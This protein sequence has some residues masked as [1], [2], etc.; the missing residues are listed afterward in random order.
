MWKLIHT[1]WNAKKNECVYRT[2]RP[3]HIFAMLLIETCN[4]GNINTSNNGAQT[5][6]VLFFVTQKGVNSVNCTWTNLII[7]HMTLWS[8]KTHWGGSKKKYK[9]ISLPRLVWRG[10]QDHITPKVCL[11]RNYKAESL[12]RLEFTKPNRFRS[13][14][15]KRN[16]FGFIEWRCI[17]SLHNKTRY[18]SL[19]QCLRRNMHHAI[20]TLHVYGLHVGGRWLELR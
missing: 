15:E 14:S 19:S 6:H 18:F 11:K 13:L 16:V 17:L 5:K 12:S 20:S 10:I 7:L 3:K 1:L 9:A 8:R 2:M 4:S